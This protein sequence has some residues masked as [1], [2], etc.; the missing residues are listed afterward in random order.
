MRTSRAAALAAMA[1]AA[2]LAAGCGDRDDGDASA[3]TDSVTLDPG[4]TFEDEVTVP[5]DA[6]GRP[7]PTATSMPTGAEVTTEVGQVPDRFPADFPI[8]EGAEVEIGS[9]GRAQ[10]ELRLSADF[11]MAESA[12]ADVADFYRE[13]IAEAGFAVLLDEQAGA[14][15]GFVGQFAFETDAYVGN[16]LVSGDGE[17]GVLLVLTATLPD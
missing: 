9:V 8:P 7:D 12:P 17:D 16:V 6:A 1:G 2:L 15:S 10:G 4:V 11:R 14:G 3:T 5:T 13:A